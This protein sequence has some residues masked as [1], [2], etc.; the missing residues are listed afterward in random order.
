MVTM[1]T[2]SGYV[3]MCVCEQVSGTVNIGFEEYPSPV[4]SP[5]NRESSKVRGVGVN[6]VD[7]LE[8]GLGE[9]LSQ[10]VGGRGERGSLQCG[11]ERERGSAQMK[12]MWG[13]E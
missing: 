5:D 1:E 11:S 6:P 10:G 7:H 9:R 13:S 12:E 8:V 2:H 4:P 3:C